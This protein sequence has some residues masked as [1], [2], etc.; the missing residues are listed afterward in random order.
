[1]AETNRYTEGETDR[2]REGKNVIDKQT[3]SERQTDRKKEKM[4][5]IQTYI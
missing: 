1:M 4:I 3:Y 2:Q 5:D